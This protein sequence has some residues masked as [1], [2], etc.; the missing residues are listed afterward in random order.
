MEFCH[1][2]YCN[3]FNL[4][5]FY[6]LSDRECHTSDPF[7][8]GLLI[9]KGAKLISALPAGKDAKE[10]NSQVSSLLS[11]L[12]HRRE[13][14]T[15]ENQKRLRMH[16]F[17][18]I[19]LL[20]KPFPSKNSQ[21][22]KDKTLKMGMLPWI[23]NKHRMFFFISL[24]MDNIS[25]QISLA[26][27]GQNLIWPNLMVLLEIFMNIERQ[28]KSRFWRQEEEKKKNPVFSL[29]LYHFFTIKQLPTPPGLNS[30]H[31]PGSEGK[32]PTRKSCLEGGIWPMD[33]SWSSYRKEPVWAPQVT[34][35]QLR[36]RCRKNIELRGIIR[37]IFFNK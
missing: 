9:T 14:A 30:D 26:S 7:N 8:K 25:F 35:T 19:S 29:S 5:K 28:T 11:F 3:F 32:N 20:K 22:Q 24:N 36:H 6:Q 13:G 18:M 17:P 34:S 33:I 21:V 27:K 1:C 31:I 37:F 23:T 16:N 15:P 2:F 4:S 12:Q 10:I